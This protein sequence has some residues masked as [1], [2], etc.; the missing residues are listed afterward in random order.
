MLLVYICEHS[1]PTLKFP[2]LFQGLYRMAS[3]LDSQRREWECDL[4]ICSPSPPGAAKSLAVV[5]KSV[6]VLTNL[7]MGGVVINSK[8]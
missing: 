6:W 7:P 1:N 3:I 4:L 2:N 5:L 8:V